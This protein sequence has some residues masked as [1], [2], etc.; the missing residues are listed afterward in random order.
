MTWVAFLSPLTSTFRTIASVV[1]RRSPPQHKCL[2]AHLIMRGIVAEIPDFLPFH[3]SDSEGSRHKGIYAIGMHLW[4][5]GLQA[6]TRS[7]FIPEA[8]LQIKLDQGIDIVGVQVISV[9]DDTLHAAEHT[10]DNSVRVDF[11]CLNPGEYLLVTLFVTNNPNADVRVTGRIVGQSG[12]VDHTAA[13]VRASVAERLSNL[14]MLLFVVNAL[15]GFLVGG[16]LIL[17]WYGWRALLNHT[18]TI[19]RYL[20]APFCAGTMIVFMYVFSRVMY[21]NERRQYPEGYPLYADLEPPLLENLQ[22]MIRTIFQAKKQR[23][24]VSLFDWGKPV[25]M[26]AKG[27]RRRTIND[28]IE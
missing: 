7:D 19:P 25:L 12:P 18:E 10:S 24:S 11:D 1:G 15:P 16:G 22:G 2:E 6:V 20:F 26:P 17:K 27:V 14:V 8:P 5:K 28:W 13:E 4:N 3:I 23:V 9:E 21:W